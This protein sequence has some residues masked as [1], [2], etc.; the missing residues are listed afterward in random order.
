LSAD[1]LSYYPPV[2]QMIGTV[3]KDTTLVLKLEPTTHERHD[4]SGYSSEVYEAKKTQ[5]LQG[6]TE[7]EKK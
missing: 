2:R 7:E 3:D 6:I 1:N 4:M 5:P